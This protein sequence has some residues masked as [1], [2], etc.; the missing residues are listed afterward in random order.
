MVNEGEEQ[1]QHEKSVQ[2]WVIHMLKLY[3]FNFINKNFILFLYKLICHLFYIS[4][5]LS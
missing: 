5:L 3:Q 2:Y 4:Q 1:Q